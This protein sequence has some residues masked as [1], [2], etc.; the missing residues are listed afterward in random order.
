MKKLEI[1]SVVMFRIGLII[2]FI[3]IAILSFFTFVLDVKA[4]VFD[5][6]LSFAF[7]GLIMMLVSFALDFISAIKGRDNK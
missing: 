3:G 4:E 1:I 6:V 5:L 7:V 2:S